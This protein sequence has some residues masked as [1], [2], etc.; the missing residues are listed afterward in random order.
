MTTTCHRSLAARSR[1]G[2]GLV[3]LSLLL[4]VGIVLYLMFGKTGST[5]YMDQV[6]K[7]RDNGEKRK[8]VGEKTMRKM[9]KTS[10]RKR[11]TKM[12][13]T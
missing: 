6:K 1:R 8:E 5:T 12:R 9:N 7:T 11:K 3:L 10:T 13:K 4:V 2:N